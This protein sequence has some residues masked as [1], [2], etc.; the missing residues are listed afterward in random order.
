MSDT[1]LAGISYS[2]PRGRATLA[3]LAAQGKLTTK[4]D[5]LQRFGF[6]Q[7]RFAVDETPYGLARQAAG[8]LLQRFDPESIDLLIYGGT[9]STAAF[10]R[11]GAHEERSMLHTLGRFKY[12]GT[13]LQSELGLT[14]AT[15]FAVSELACATLFGAIRVARALAHTEG[16]KRS[17]C[18]A[19]EFF[20]EDAGRE[21]LFNC[22]SDAACAVL[23]EEGAER[24]RIVAQAQVTKGYY[25]D[26]EGS[27]DEIVASYFPTAR[28]VIEQVLERAGWR[29]ED[30]TWIL[31]HNV[32]LRS[33]EILLGLL[34]LPRARLFDR[35]I[36]PNGHSLA[37]DNFINLADA[38]DAG[39]I[40]AGD[41]LLLFSYGFGAHWSALAVEA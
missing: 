29:R 28:Y 9:P 7:V 6:E 8:T 3:E 5:V 26:C 23:L 37:G 34:R 27:R 19:S 12:P 39:E 1:G 22:T 38:L 24:N 13:R 10:A 21:A 25:W 14:R 4:P 36:R 33:W 31:P 30:V 11:P 2:F 17:L 20:P 40:R 32:S 41:R 16:L 35:N 15:S 18:V